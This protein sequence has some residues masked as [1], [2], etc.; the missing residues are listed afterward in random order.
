[1]IA[2]PL[3]RPDGLY[4]EALISQI[5]AKGTR[6]INIANRWALGWPGRVKQLIEAGEG[7][8]MTE[9]L[10][11]LELEWDMEANAVGLNHLSDAEKRQFFGVPEAPPAPSL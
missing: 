9:L 2:E 4:P 11:Q 10:K 3:Y 1:M 6:A 5:F 8:Y 7:R